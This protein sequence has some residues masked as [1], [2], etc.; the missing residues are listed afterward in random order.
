MSSRTTREVERNTRSNDYLQE[1]IQDFARNAFVTAQ[2]DLLKTQVALTGEFSEEQISNDGG[3][4]QNYEI[5]E[6]A[7]DALKQSMRDIADFAATMGDEIEGVEQKFRIPRLGGKRGRIARARAFATDAEPYRDI[8]VGRGLDPDFIENLRAKADAL[9][10]ALSAAVSKTADRVGSTESKMIAHKKSN[11]I[12]A[13]LDPVIRRL[14]R[15]NPAKLAAW[16]FASRI[17][18]DSAA[19]VKPPTTP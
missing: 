9:E 4:R 5:A 15:D 17:Q 19:K 12:I 3:A 2:S 1:N 8:F 11:K 7:N 18:R 6:E 16:D 13:A 10:N 14:Y